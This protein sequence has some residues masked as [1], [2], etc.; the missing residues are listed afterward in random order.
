MVV[1]DQ[2][3]APGQPPLGTTDP[4]FGKPLAVVSEGRLTVYVYPNDISKQLGPR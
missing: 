1:T 2:M 4:A 3:T